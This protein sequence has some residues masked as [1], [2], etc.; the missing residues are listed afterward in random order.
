MV[1]KVDNLTICQ[2]LWKYNDFYKPCSDFACRF[3][4]TRPSEG[5]EVEEKGVGHQLTG[6]GRVVCR[7]NILCV[8]HDGGVTL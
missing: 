7:V 3:V 8:T 6:L 2:K 5:D 1:W 4:N